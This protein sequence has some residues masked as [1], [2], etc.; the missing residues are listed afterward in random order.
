MKEEKRERCCQKGQYVQYTVSRFFLL[1]RLELGPFS[2]GRFF[3]G[4]CDSLGAIFRGLSGRLH[5]HSRGGGMSH[6]I[7]EEHTHAQPEIDGH[8]DSTQQNHSFKLMA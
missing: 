6:F 5:A 2:K 3:V 1:L 4:L 7:H 8:A